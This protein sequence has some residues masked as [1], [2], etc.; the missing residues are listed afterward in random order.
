LYL[1][2]RSSH[3]AFDFVLDVDFEIA[4]DRFPQATFKDGTTAEYGSHLDAYEYLLQEEQNVVVQ[5]FMSTG[6]QYILN[7]QAGGVGPNANAENLSF[8]QSHGGPRSAGIPPSISSDER[9]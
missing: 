1:E 4:P 6:D 8:R 2:C 9:K 5:H 7:G 3:G